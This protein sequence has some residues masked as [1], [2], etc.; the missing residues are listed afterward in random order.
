MRIFSVIFIK[1]ERTFG[2]T[3]LVIYVIGLLGEREEEEL[4]FLGEVERRRRVVLAFDDDGSGRR[5]E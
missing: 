2:I 4:L 1:V 5:D 3:V